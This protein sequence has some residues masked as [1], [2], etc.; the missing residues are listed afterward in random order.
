MKGRKKPE[1]P[2]DKKRRPSK[3]KKKPKKPRIR[4][5]RSRIRE[6]V[7]MDLRGRIELEH[8]SPDRWGKGGKGDDIW[9]GKQR[10]GAPPKKIKD[11]KVVDS[12]PT[13]SCSSGTKLRHRGVTSGKGKRDENYATTCPSRGG[14]K[15]EGREARPDHYRKN[16]RLSASP[17]S[18]W[19]RKLFTHAE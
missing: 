1:F 8:S 2:R 19:D 12:G 5:G 7:P 18:R 4:Q 6:K 13:N 17:E 9:V 16:A 11:V 3:K 15:N 10:G 14:S